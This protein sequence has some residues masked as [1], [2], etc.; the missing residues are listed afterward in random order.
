[1]FSKRKGSAE[2]GVVVGL[3]ILVVL[4]FL[5][6]CFWA[7]NSS[8]VE[9]PGGYVG[10]VTQGAI[11]G[12]KRFVGTQLGPVSSGKIWKYE[13][14]NV[15]VTPYTYDEMFKQEDKTSVLSKDGMQIAYGVHIT[16]RVNP[17]RVKD[18]VEHYSTLQTGD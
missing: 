6:F 11:F 10:Y 5:S 13:V 8:N 3:G 16:F 15:S 18:F 17:D 12:Q 2:S 14:I 1:M 9:T 7:L 4:G